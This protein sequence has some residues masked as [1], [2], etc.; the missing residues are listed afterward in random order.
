MSDTTEPV[1]TK[2][3]VECFRKFSFRSETYP[4]LGNVDFVYQIDAA[5]IAP[6][7]GIEP[8]DFTEHIAFRQERN[9]LSL[10]PEF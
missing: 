8:F 10:F 7:Q 9:A 4:I 3:T 2:D 5:E 1:A 6:Q